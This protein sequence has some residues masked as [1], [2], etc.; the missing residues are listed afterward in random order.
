MSVSTSCIVLHQNLDFEKKTAKWVPKLVSNKQKQ[1]HVEVCTEFV[2]AVNCHSL[3]MLDSI[4]VMDKIM[5][6]YHTLQTKKQS[7]L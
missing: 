7:K 2:T 5:L 4:V 1:Q 3:A 6:C